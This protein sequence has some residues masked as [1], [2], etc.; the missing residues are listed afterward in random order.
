KLKHLNA[1]RYISI[2]KHITEYLVKNKIPESKIS[3]IRCG[4]KIPSKPPAKINKKLK[5]VTASRHVKEKGIDLF[6]KA[7]SVI[8][9]N[10]LDFIIAGSGEEE[11]NLKMLNRKLKAGVTFAG[12]IK[13]LSNFLKE[14]DI[15]V[16]TGRSLT[17]G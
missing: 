1:D 3:F 10:D 7:A 13:D 8:K 4:I 11:N 16:F 15:F 12:E 17:E 14:S 5:I 2:N 6:I 9:K